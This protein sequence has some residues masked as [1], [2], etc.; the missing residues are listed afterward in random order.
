[1]SMRWRR[2]EAINGGFGLVLDGSVDA[3]RRAKSVLAWDVN[4]GV[5]FTSLHIDLYS[6]IVQPH[7]ISYSFN[8]SR[9]IK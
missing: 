3:E 9:Q 4:N 8:M 6:F 2:G 7:Q 1:M 5:R